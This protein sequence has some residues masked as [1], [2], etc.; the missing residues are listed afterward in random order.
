MQPNQSIEIKLVDCQGRLVRLGN[1]LP[2]ITFFNGGHRHYRFDIKPTQPDGRTLVDYDELE[3]RRQEK[4]PTNLM[5]YNTPL[6][7]LDPFVE[8]SIPSESELRQ[9]VQGMEEWDHWS[10]PAWV[11]KW[12]RN[13]CLAPVEPKRVELRE[14]ITRVEI[15]I[16]LPTDPE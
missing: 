16:S 5:D 14:P 2:R 12:P 15:V 9:R 3:T 8:I 13:G 1:V 10:R 6:T 7:A 4:R 11:L